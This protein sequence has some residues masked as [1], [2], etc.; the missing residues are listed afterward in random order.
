MKSA[1][2]ARTEAELRAWYAAAERGDLFPPMT[3]EEEAEAWADI[4]ALL[5]AIEKRDGND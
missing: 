4:E 1:L 3:P 5:D 2:E